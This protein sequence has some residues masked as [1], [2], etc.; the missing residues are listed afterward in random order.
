[1][2]TLNEMFKSLTKKQKESLSDFDCRPDFDG[3][4]K[5]MY[6]FNRLPRAEQIRLINE[7]K[8]AYQKFH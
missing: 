3:A 8:K 5:D 4:I 1:M 6:N 2:T 7:G